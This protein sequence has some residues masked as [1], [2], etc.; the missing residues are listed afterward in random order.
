MGI[1]YANP[2]YGWAGCLTFPRELTLDAQG[3][4]RMMPVR[5][6]EA[7]HQDAH[8]LPAFSLNNQRRRLEASALQAEIH[9]TWDVQKSQAERFGIEIAISDDRCYATRLYVNTQSRHLVLDRSQSGLCIG[10]YRSVALP[11]RDKLELRLFFDRSFL[12]VFV[13]QG[14]M[15]LTSRIY[16]PTEGAVSPFMPKM[17]MRTVWHLTIGR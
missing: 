5:E 2:D 12:E 1:R 14:E 11:D 4:V 6:L 17:G 13:N 16:P 8:K 10:G 3:H 9:V 15:C 7:L